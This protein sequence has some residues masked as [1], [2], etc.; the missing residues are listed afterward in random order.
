ME[1]PNKK[2]KELIPFLPKK[3]IQ[4][5]EKYFVARDFQA[6]KEIVDS[7]IIR[8]KKSLSSETPKEEY[9]SID[10]DKLY[11]LQSTV[12]AYIILIGDIDD[13]VYENDDEGALDCNNFEESFYD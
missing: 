10:L 13:E 12:D 11:T 9:L 3:D 5:A 8:I 4:F 2:I 6:L 7:S 1:S